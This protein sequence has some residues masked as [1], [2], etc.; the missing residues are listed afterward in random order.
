MAGSEA[1]RGFAVNT[2]VREAHLPDLEELL[3]LAA[4]AEGQVGGEQGLRRALD[5]GDDGHIVLAMALDDGLAGF[6]H[7][8]QVLDEVTVMDLLVTPARRRQGLAGELLLAGLARTRRAGARRC[9]LEVRAAND[10]AINLY[11]SFGFLRDGCRKGYYPGEHGR[12]DAILMSLELA[13]E[14]TKKTP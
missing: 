10:P 8:H 9:L 4:T 3:A 6:I 2:R 1:P 12:E 14:E 5:S 13:P 11:R 7:M